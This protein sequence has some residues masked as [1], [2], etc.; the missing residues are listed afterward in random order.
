MPRKLAAGNF[1]PWLAE[2]RAAISGKGSAN[3]PCGTCTA[4]CR[5]HNILIAA[6]ETETL[7][8][9]ASTLQ[10]PASR[11]PHGDL[12]MMHEESGDCPML[13]DERCS[14]YEHRPRMCRTYDCRVFPA[15]G[16]AAGE[17]KPVIDE[18]AQR[19]SFS[20]PTSADRIE[21]DAVLAAAS[22]L[23]DNWQLLA[24]AEIPTNQIQLALAA[25]EMYDLFMPPDSARADGAAVADT[26][27]PAVV[28]E[29]S[30]RRSRR[31]VH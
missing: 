28:V 23:A 13:V 30:R 11:M 9:V 15:S 7:A 14:I 5:T 8:H 2:T 3:V 4:C 22:L 21:Y 24:E 1:S 31:A 16:L 6:D 27:P 29:L 17:D 20:Y 25:V 19:W 26:T 18:Q 12:L 10:I